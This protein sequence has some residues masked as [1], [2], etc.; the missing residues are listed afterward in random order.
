[1]EILGYLKNDTAGSEGGTARDQEPVIA[2][3]GRP[4]ECLEAVGSNPKAGQ[5]WNSPQV[6]PFCWSQIGQKKF[7]TDGHRRTFGGGSD[8]AEQDFA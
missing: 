2:G 8:R 5:V 4:G 1:M 6:S 7:D 3:T